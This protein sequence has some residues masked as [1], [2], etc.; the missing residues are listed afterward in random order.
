MSI[1]KAGTMNFILYIKCTDQQDFSYSNPFY[2]TLKG[3][4][5]NADFLDLDNFSEAE[6]ID[7]A[8]KAITEADK[9]CIVF[10]FQSGNDN[11][12][13][14]PLATFLADHPKK[15]YVFLNGS[16][17]FLNKLLFPQEN[18]SYHNES[19]EWQIELITNFFAS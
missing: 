4:I 18:F 5:K 15:K 9:S 17:P 14:L 8:L 10:D 16:D 2:E 7:Y 3:K 1:S 6:L 19:K 11:K 13:F 12:R